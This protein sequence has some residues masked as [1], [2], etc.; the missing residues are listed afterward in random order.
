MNHWQPVNPFL[1]LASMIA[2]I[3]IALAACTGDSG[4]ELVQAAREGNIRA[5]RILLEAGADA[6]ANDRK[7]QSS[8]LM[9]AAHEGH[10]DVMNLLIENGA[11]VDEQRSTGETA[12]WFTAQ[13]GQLEAMKILVN[14]GADI[15]VVS[16]EDKSALDIA[17]QN[18]YQEIVH[19]LRAT[20][21]SPS[22]EPADELVLGIKGHQFTI[23]GRPSFLLG[24]S[25]FDASNWRESDLI[26]IAANNF[27]L[28][29]IWLYW[30]VDF[31]VPDNESFFDNAGNL[32]AKKKLVNLVKTARK[33]G[34]VVDVTILEPKSFSGSQSKRKNAVI[35]TANALK[36][37]T[38][39][40]FDIMNEHD[41]GARSKDRFPAS[42]GEIAELIQ[43]LRHQ[44]PDAI[45][46]VS[47]GGRHHVSDMVLQA[48]N[49]KEEIDSG[50]EV[51]S[52][53]FTRTD[54]WYSV[55]DKRI[56]SILNYLD[57]MELGRP[58]YLQEEQ[59]RNYKG[60]NVSMDNFIESYKKAKTSGAAGWN[61]HTSAG[62]ELGTSDFFS[63][64]D[65]VE[66]DVINY[67]RRN[68]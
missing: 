35:A 53:H 54:D 27:D 2:A 51:I 17:S 13:K 50:V 42:H 11:D 68:G 59:R 14:H 15:N 19:Y 20:Q 62:F 9:W 31:S 38:N 67:F 32:V 57:S 25:Y 65:S 37:E 10:T 23:N 16:R 61:F 24:V 5:A 22:T 3:T 1:T 29:R 64:L 45:I 36:N 34:L 18:G 6:N 33:H 41:V 56:D 44:K 28:I 48:T 43:A 26:E 58:V 52:P 8:A 66:K 30:R 60:S 63:N 49:I 40:L 47:G 21:S 4:E 12:L 7:H 46:T 55:T 39:I